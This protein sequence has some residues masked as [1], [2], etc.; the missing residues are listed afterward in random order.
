M[1]QPIIAQSLFYLGTILTNP[2]TL[3]ICGTLNN[4]PFFG[5]YSTRLAYVANSFATG[6][7]TILI[8]TQ[9]TL[10][11]LVISGTYVNTTQDTLKIEI[12]TIPVTPSVTS[13]VSAVTNFQDVHFD[14]GPLQSGATGGGGLTFNVVIEAGGATFQW[15]VNGGAYTVGVPC[16][17]TPTNLSNNV[18]V[19]F[20]RTAGYTP[21]DVFTLYIGNTADVVNGNSDFYT[22]SRLV[23]TGTPPN[24][25]Q[26]NFAQIQGPTPITTPFVY[27]GNT[28][29]FQTAVQNT[30]YGHKVGDSWT[31]ELTPAVNIPYVNIYF[32]LPARKPGQGAVIHLDAIPIAF[33]PQ[34]N[35]MYVSERSGLFQTLEFQT[36]ADLLTEEIVPDRL[37][38]SFSNKVLKQGLVTHTKDSIAYINIENQLVDLGRVVNQFATPMSEILSQPIQNDFSFINFIQSLN[39][40]GNAHINF[41]DNKL[42]VCVPSVGFYWIYDYIYEF[43][44]PPQTGQFSSVSVINGQICAHSAISN[45]T[46]ILFSASNDNGFPFESIMALPYNS[47]GRFPQTLR[48]LM[49]SYEDTGRRD[50]LK[51]YSKFFIEAYK[52]AN[53]NLYGK[54]NLEW[55]NCLGGPD[56][57]LDPKICAPID[58]ASLGKSDLGKH[59]LA[60]DPLLELTKFHFFQP[61]N[62]QFAYEAQLIFHSSSPDNYWK[63]VSCGTNATLADQRNVVAQTPAGTQ[64]VPISNAIAGTPKPEPWAGGVN[65]PGNIADSTANGGAS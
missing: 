30:P 35:L 25:F 4:H 39:G 56:L 63:V 37:K 1:T 18:T 40:V 17:I 53:T 65:I 43:W 52:T 45:E 22:V 36:S 34:E 12:I 8:A 61:F 24:L 42:F 23:V 47:D 26:G 32:S 46:Y 21:G 20:G 9:T 13:S 50:R 38:T 11:D 19:A 6:A 15:N 14:F 5:S 60:N 62:R 10:D 3:D 2:P 58:R 31:I 64:P 51:E 54:V 29:T 33:I 16:T 49:N 48:M 28:F 55:G 44:Q 41:A 7:T 27:N 59:G 57:R